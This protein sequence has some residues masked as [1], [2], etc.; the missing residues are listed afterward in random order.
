MRVCMSV[1]H[2]Q[3]IRRGQ[4]ITSDHQ[5]LEL[6]VGVSHRVGTGNQSLVLCKSS[7]FS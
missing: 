7:N 5:E 4:E 6:Q 2:V 1:H 3:S